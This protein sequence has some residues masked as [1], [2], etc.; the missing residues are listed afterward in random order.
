[1]VGGFTYDDN[2]K[3]KEVMSYDIENDEWHVVSRLHTP[4][5]SVPCCALYLP[6]NLLCSSTV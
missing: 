6:R 3:R 4:A 2:K 1:M 5:M